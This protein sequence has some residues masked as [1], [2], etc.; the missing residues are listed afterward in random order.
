MSVHWNM[1]VTPFW[2]AAHHLGKVAL[3]TELTLQIHPIKRWNSSVSGLFTFELC[4]TDPRDPRQW[5]PKFSQL[6]NFICFSNCN[7]VYLF[8]FCSKEEQEKHTQL[9]LHCRSGSQAGDFHNTALL[10]AICWKSLLP[11][12]TGFMIL[13]NALFARSGVL[14]ARSNIFQMI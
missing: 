13:N 14:C 7:F 9:P 6:A 12:Y 8:G 11:K 2:F 10:I 3:Q 5:P 1:P 4:H